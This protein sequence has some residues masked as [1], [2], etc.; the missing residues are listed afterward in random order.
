MLK[1]IIDIKEKKLKVL[2]YGN[3]YLGNLLADQLKEELVA[4][5]DK[6]LLINNKKENNIISLNEIKN[7]EYDC[8]IISVIGRE[9]E[10]IKL[11]LNNTKRHI[12]NI[13]TINIFI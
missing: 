11:L 13:L 4:I 2:L 1:K 7:Y 12:T 9:M 10:I 6:D 3:G 8:I 5:V